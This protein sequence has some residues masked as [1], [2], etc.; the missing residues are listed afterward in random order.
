MTVNIWLYDTSEPHPD[1]PAK[2]ETLKMNEFSLLMRSKILSVILRTNADKLLF[3]NSVDGKPFLSD[4][5]DIHFNVSHSSS[6]WG[7]AVT[8]NNCEI[9]FDI[10]NERERKFMDK[11]I[12]THFHPK[13]FTD[14]INI[15]CEEKRMSY[16]YHL[17]TQ[18]ES[19]AKYLG[20]GLKYDFS[21]DCFIDKFPD[22]ANIFS[23]CIFSNQKS[24]SKT[25]F[26][27][28]CPCISS[29]QN[30]KFIGYQSLIIQFPQE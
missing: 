18:K 7:M 21:R 23:G 10:E 12:E 11:I 15:S 30:I 24:S 22:D 4:F 16:F 13:E 9:G 19:Y 2:S 17:W 1:F 6:L 28:A 14:Y 8:Y 5:D 25:Y 27:I 29:S 26:S 3:S 20:R